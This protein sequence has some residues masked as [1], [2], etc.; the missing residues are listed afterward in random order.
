MS[1]LIY[2]PSKPEDA[3]VYRF[4]KLQVGFV[5]SV[6]EDLIGRVRIHRELIK[7]R[8]VNPLAQRAW[9]FKRSWSVKVTTHNQPPTYT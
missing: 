7:Q 9:K 8:K 1:D 3:S 5:L 6:L 2:V 4:G